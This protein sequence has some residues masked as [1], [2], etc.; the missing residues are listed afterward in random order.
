MNLKGIRND[1][2]PHTFPSVFLHTTY[3]LILH[4]LTHASSHSLIHS[5]RPQA[6]V[7]HKPWVRHRAR[8][9]GLQN[10][11]TEG[12]QEQQPPKGEGEGAGISLESTDALSFY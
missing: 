3:L 4:G 1:S 2:P 12:A 5:F 9:R 11:E 8:S 7:E 10:S 6:Y